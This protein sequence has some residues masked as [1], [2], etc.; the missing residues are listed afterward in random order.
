MKVVLVAPPIMD[1]RDGV[2]CPIAMDAVRECPP[3]GIYYLAGIL[4]GE[5]HEVVV[6]DLIAL[7]TNRID[8]FL[9]DIAQCQLVGIG[10]TTL[11]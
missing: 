4:R 8:P 6:A 7:G 2:L 11:A 5:G 3:Y 1:Y 9:P 10:A